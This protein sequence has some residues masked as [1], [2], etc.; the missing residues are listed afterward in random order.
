MVLRNGTNKPIHVEA[1][2]TELHMDGLNTINPGKGYKL[3]RT[4]NT[5]LTISSEEG[6]CKIKFWFGKMM[7]PETEGA[8]RLSIEGNRVT[9]LSG[10]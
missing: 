8:L 5:E 7:E 2:H 4:T 9:V 3:T 10:S 6:K 1:P